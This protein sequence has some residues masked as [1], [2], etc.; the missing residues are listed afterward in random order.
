MKTFTKFFFIFSIVFLVLGVSTLQSQINFQ[1][2]YSEGEGGA[3]WDADGSGPEPNGNG[4]GN[5]YYYTA[6]R[7]YVDP[8]YS[9]GA[10]M[11]DNMNGFPLFEQALLNNG[12][13]AE[14]VTLKI[15]LASMGDDI[16]G[17]DWFTI[18]N[19]GYANFYPAIGTVYLNSAPLFEIIGNYALYIT[20][21]GSQEFESGFLKV[22]NISGNSPDPVKN[23]ATALMA[24][25]DNEEFKFYMQVTN[26]AYLSGNGR[27]GGYFNINCSMVK[28]LPTLPV[29]GLTAENEGT[30]GWDADG[31]GPEPYGNGHQMMVYYCASVDYDDINSDPNACL[32]HC[33]EGSNGFLN[34]MLQLQYRG[35]TISDLKIKMGLAS[36]GPDVEGEDWG[37]QNG[38][39]WV[40]EYNNVFTFEINGEPILQMLQDTMKMVYYNSYWTI[41]TSIGKMYDISQ[42]AS[43]D[44]QFVAQSFLRD[45]GTHY[46]VWDIPSLTYTGS[47]TG[48]GRDGVYYQIN[49]GALKGKHEQATFVSEGNVSGNWV[50]SGSP[51]YVEGHLEIAN[52]ETLTI[53]PGVRIGVRGPYHFNVQG[54]LKAEG[55]P[56]QNI[57]FTSSNPNLWWDG[58]DFDETPVENDTSRFNHCIFQYGLAQGTSPQYNSGGAMAGRNVDKIKIQ[59]TVFR[60]NKAIL[61]GLYP[62]CGGAIA[63]DNSDILIHNCTLYDN[64][65]KYG[66][67]VFCYLGSDPTI[68]RCLFYNNT[69]ESD[70]GAIQIWDNCKPVI[71]N[72]TFSLNN[73]GSNGGAIDVYSFSNP[74]FV[75]NIFWEN[76]ANALGQQ[77]SITSDFCNVSITY[78]DVQGGETG[79]GPYG[80]QS[81]TYENNIDVDP[82]FLDIANYNFLLDSLAPSP[83][84][85][86]GDPA[87]QPDP[88]GTPA[89]MGCY[90]QDIVT[91]LATYTKNDLQLY[92]NPAFR[93]III[94]NDLPGNANTRIEVFNVMGQK[95]SEP[96]IISSIENKILLDVSHLQKGTYF[97]KW[98]SGEEVRTAKFV[99]K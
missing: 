59:N 98:V 42:N 45:V 7:D 4:H 99:K 66:G 71:I 51:Y 94:V 97:C 86:A 41:N 29:K 91:G 15:S 83:C 1:G 37:I 89:D 67:A 21:P 77:I 44:A 23:V 81:G 9:S 69:A 10:H 52:G 61:S 35:F 34:T 12:F 65:A 30:A 20:S 49:S 64:L 85:N 22:N 6:S 60:H 50:L 28:G 11:L 75:N 39:D 87:T 82:L 47:F 2:L 40:N 13:T 95:V 27:S 48:N 17:I 73:A 16:E 25:L 54:C 84:I 58:L 79:I 93:E 63:I 46:L 70:A 96:R 33:L 57:I 92:P 53:E 80:I 8:T 88:D 26:V 19:V 55:T 3:A 36:F 18:G 62:P 14:Q 5:F 74:V 43:P 68:S 72:N 76:E 31:T 32:A 24:D 38:H 78:C 90:F 56:D